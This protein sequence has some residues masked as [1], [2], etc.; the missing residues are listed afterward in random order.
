MP[1]AH[2]RG[3]VTVAHDESMKVVS[4]ARIGASLGKPPL[5]ERRVMFEDLQ[6]AVLSRFHW[7]AN[8]CRLAAAEQ[9]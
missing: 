1:F 4:Q 2:S 5:A 9:S 6:I 8:A 3:Y 7:E